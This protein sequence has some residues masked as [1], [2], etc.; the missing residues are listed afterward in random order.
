MPVTGDRILGR[1]LALAEPALAGL[2]ATFAVS[3]APAPGERRVLASAELGRIARSHGISTSELSEVCFE[4]PVR[5]LSRE[6]ISAAMM[7]SLPSS[8]HVEIVELGKTDAPPGEID[9][10]SSGLEPADAA[11]NRLW[12]GSVRYAPTRKL[13]VWARVKVLDE[14]TAVV[15]AR[16]I[17]AGVVVEEGW[18]RLEK[19]SGVLPREPFARRIEDAA[20]LVL[21]RPVKSGAP[22]PLATLSV[23][24]A[25]RRGETVRVDVASGWARLHFEAVAESDAREGDQIALRNPISGKT[26]R[27][28]VGGNGRATVVIGGPAI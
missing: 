28:K 21:K 9:F 2:P 22:L 27:A 8:A 1:D 6:E 25:V 23:P 16:D 15:A 4:L 3:F 26:F 19:Q 7:R 10:P 14:Y 13:A 11:G 20:G 17:P 24:L 18:L 5:K 12:R